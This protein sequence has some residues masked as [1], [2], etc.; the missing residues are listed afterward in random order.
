MGKSTF[1]D[2]TLTKLDKRFGLRQVPTHPVL[3][4]W[5]NG[6]ADISAFE[7]TFLTAIKQRATQHVEYWNEQEYALQGIGQ[8]MTL[9]DFSHERFNLFANRPVAAL[10]DGEELSGN[11]D[12]LIASGWREPEIPYFCLQ[13]YKKEREP[14]GD[15]AGQCLAAM[16]AAQELNARQHP[17]Y[18]GYVVRRNWFFMVLQG[19]EYAISNSYA[20]THDE[21]CDIL[22]ILKALKAILIEIA[23][24][25]A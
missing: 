17:V 11:P 14:E 7:H 16:L 10:V 5:L 24:Q 22:R 25:D 6:Q 12:G 1:R 20:I 9:A 23:K 8:M 13:E 3:D 15:P 19:A 18:G 4:A 21:I 2:W